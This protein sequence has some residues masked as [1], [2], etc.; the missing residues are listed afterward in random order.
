MQPGPGVTTPKVTWADAGET[1]I[2]TNPI[3][4]DARGET[5]VFW[6]G[7]YNV[8][9]E[10]AA[11]NLIYTVENIA[12]GPDANADNISYTPSGTSL[13]PVST[14]KDALDTLS[15][16]STGSDF[17]G[18]LQS[19]ANAVRRSSRSK[20]R[21]VVSV[22]DF[23]A[24]GNGIADD[25]LAIQAAINAVSAA[26][27]A[28]AGTVLFPHARY[29]ITAPL[30]L[31]IGVHLELDGSTIVQAT[32]N[33]PI[34]RTPVGSDVYHWG[35]SNGILEYAV[36]QSNTQTGA[37]G[38]LISSGSFSYNFFVKDLQVS[39]ACDGI[40]CPGTSGTFAFVGYFD[41]VLA[42]ICSR[43]GFNIDCDT[44]VG[45]NTNLTFLNCWSLQNAGAPIAGSRGFR[46]RGCSQSRWE[47]LFADHLRGPFL[48]METCVG[49][50]G[51]LTPES[52]VY[53]SASGP[54]SVITLA[55]CS[56]VIQSLRWIANTFT[57]GANDIYLLRTTSSGPQYRTTIHQWLGN[58]NVYAG[59]LANLYEVNP[60]ANTR[61]VNESLI[62]DRVENLADTGQPKRITRWNGVDRTSYDT[63]GVTIYGTA[64]PTTGTWTR[65]A[66]CIST[67]VSDLKP[68]IEW[69][70]STTG[71]PGAWTAGR[72]LVPRN[73][74]ANRPTLTV[75]DKGVGYLDTT[76]AANGQ[77][78]TWTGT[79]WVNSSG[80]AV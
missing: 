14:V 22:K 9:L 31:A 30:T 3:I 24:I 60:S 40:G 16:Q 62:I 19:G 35:I 65:G 2:K 15:N 55:D 58:S 68:V 51:C 48:E 32:N 59:T 17:V 28:F 7:T 46:F 36:Q 38:L 26:A 29:R 44:A 23:G 53:D 41:Q 70:C 69:V 37:V 10:T 11:G 39:Y 61:I 78:I 77:P 6:S 18:F 49:E 45:A 33:V 52:C 73:T 42:V 43:Y 57:V 67:D 21:D 25:T 1:V 66:K 20:M 50:I 5:T 80:T 47:S 13:L 8:R 75:A 79:L 74:T 63:S 76:L 34:V 54:I 4:L 56:L 72:W 27:T 64:P 71:T 12:A